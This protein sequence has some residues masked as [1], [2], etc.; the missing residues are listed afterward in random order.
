MSH[1]FP[2]TPPPA[3]V[4]WLLAALLAIPLAI[5]V[6]TTGHP[7]AMPAFAFGVLVIA[8]TAGITFWG[9]ARRNVTLDGR[10]LVVRAALFTHRLDAGDL[11]LDRARIIDL[12]ERTELKPILKTFGMALPG[13]KAGW[14]LLRNRGRAFCLLTTHRRVLW[15]P[16]R[17][18]KALLLSLERPDTLLDALR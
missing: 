9:L 6:V 12:D 13:F 10:L 16:T 4:A 17:A 7:S 5:I 8:A 2:V 18:G 15:L 14:F 3:H 1:T 11:E